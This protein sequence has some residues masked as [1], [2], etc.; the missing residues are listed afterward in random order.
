MHQNR[1]MCVFN[2]L[3]E[4]TTLLR[5]SGQ[6]LLGDLEQQFEQK[7][8]NISESS[9]NAINQY[10]KI[11]GTELI[12]SN[13]VKSSQNRPKNRP[14]CISKSSQNTWSYSRLP[15]ESSVTVI[16]ELQLQLLTNIQLVRGPTP[17]RLQRTKTS[18]VAPYKGVPNKMN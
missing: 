7:L 10:R 3:R 1:L 15:P 11:R 18:E 14:K 5:D 2:E 9:Q 17:S 6:R 12:F 13:N 8:S 4:L 16:T